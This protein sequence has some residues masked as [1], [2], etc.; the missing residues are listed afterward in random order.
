MRAGGQGPHGQG[1]RRA[2]AAHQEPAVPV[3]AA[4]LQ[5]PVRPLR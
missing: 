5:H 2:G 1:H 4:L 3:H